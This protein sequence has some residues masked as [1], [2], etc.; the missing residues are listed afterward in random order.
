MIKILL[1]ILVLF[2]SSCGKLKGKP[3]DNGI[4]GKDGINGLN[5]ANGKD[6]INGTDGID[7]QNGKDGTSCTT[8]TVIGGAIIKC[9][10]GTSSIIVNGVNGKDGID[11]KDGQNAIVELI[12][13]CG[14]NPNIY[15][16]I[17]IRLNNNKLIAY[18][19][20]G[21][22][23]YLTIIIPGTYQTTDK[24]RCIF[25]ITDNYEVRW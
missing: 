1:I 20:D 5:G 18:F 23:H 4:P 11:G 25:T 21:T 10:D 12:D 17:L 24:Q 7:G 13:P 6:G 14:D 22:Q 8:E 9:S 15:D 19:E 3:G 16:E 2:V